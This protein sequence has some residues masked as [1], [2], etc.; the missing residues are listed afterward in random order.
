MRTYLYVDGENH[1]IRSA[2]L[3]REIKGDKGLRD[4]LLL[5]ARVVPNDFRR[6]A[7]NMTWWPEPHRRALNPT[8]LLYTRDEVYWDSLGLY[9][10]C[11]AELIEATPSIARA[12]YFTSCAGPHVDEHERRLHG[13]GFTPHVEVRVKKDSWAKELAA[14]G[15]TVVSRPKPQDILIA[16]RVLEDCAGDNFD[17]CIFVG[18]DGDYAPLLEAVR[19]R[20]KEVWLI[21]LDRFLGKGPLRFACDRF[22]PYDPVLA[23]RPLPATPPPAPDE[24]GSDS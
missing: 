9:L 19:R 20:G 18:G 11:Y 10:A 12:Y 21:A 15:I 6:D 3:D 14:Q 22:I 1:T 23:V 16:T 5:Q 2:S 17:R 8:A 4:G 24:A 7:R 13:I